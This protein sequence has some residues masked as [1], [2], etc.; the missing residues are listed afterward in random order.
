LLVG[1]LV[2]GATVGFSLIPTEK[3]DIFSPA[4]QPLE[5]YLDSILSSYEQY[6]SIEDALTY[7]QWQASEISI[8]RLLGPPGNL[9]QNMM[10]VAKLT[11]DRKV[12]E[13]LR[14]YTRE[15]VDYLSQAS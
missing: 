9:K 6:A 12:A 5:N 7:G 4:N 13:K 3:L 14:Q 11:E 2:T 1:L 8:K 10:A 15:C